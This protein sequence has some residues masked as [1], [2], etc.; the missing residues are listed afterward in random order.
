ML[1]ASHTGTLAHSIALVAIRVA[2][3]SAPKAKMIRITR[4]LSIREG[5]SSRVITFNTSEDRPSVKIMTACFNTS[6]RST[7]LTN[8]I[9]HYYL[10]KKLLTNCYRRSLACGSLRLNSALFFRRY[11]RPLRAPVDSV[12]VNKPSQKTRAGLL[13]IIPI[14]IITRIS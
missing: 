11:P 5:R 2:R 3:T 10:H 14:N 1:L 13:I 8:L 6:R 12:S 7:N 9:F 4:P